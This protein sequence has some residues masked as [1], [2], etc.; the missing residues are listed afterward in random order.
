M[1]KEKKIKA[2]LT[3]LEKLFEDL[4]D[5]QLKLA[6]GLLQNAAFMAVTLRDLQQEV[7]GKGAVIVCQSG[8]GFA[9]IKD[10]PAQKAYTTMVARYTNI[11]AKLSAMLP[12]EEEEDPL[13]DFR[14]D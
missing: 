7:I 13:D 1:D 12:P 10:N 9:T 14:D 11:I 8:N 2:E 6:A 5:N 3:K 4:P